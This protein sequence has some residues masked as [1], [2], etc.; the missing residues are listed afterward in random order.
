MFSLEM[1]SL[2]LNYFFIAVVSI[3][4]LFSHVVH[5]RTIEYVTNVLKLSVSDVI[6][7]QK[8]SNGDKKLQFFGPDYNFTCSLCAKIHLWAKIHSIARKR[9]KQKS[10]METIIAVEWNKPDIFACWAVKFLKALFFSV[11][12]LFQMTLFPFKLSSFGPV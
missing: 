3:W 5:F 6:V 1:P 4:L 7:S 8:G 9:Q 2:W 11:T 12:V 10:P